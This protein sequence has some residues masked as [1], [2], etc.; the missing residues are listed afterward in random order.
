MESDDYQGVDKNPSAAGFIKY[1]TSKHKGAKASKAIDV[2]DIPADAK[3]LAKTIYIDK[4]INKAKEIKAKIDAKKEKE[5][6][7][8]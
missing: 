6:D 3:K 1:I 4:D 5:N 7:K 2:M 8:S